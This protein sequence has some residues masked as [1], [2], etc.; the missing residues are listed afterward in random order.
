MNLTHL[1]LLQLSFQYS[2]NLKDGEWFT[3]RVVFHAGKLRFNFQHS[4]VKE[5]RWQIP[6]PKELLTFRADN[7]ELERISIRQFYLC[8]VSS[9]FAQHT[10]Q[11][12]KMQNSWSVNDNKSHYTSIAQNDNY[13]LNDLQRCLVFVLLCFI[14]YSQDM[15]L[16]SNDTNNQQQERKEREPLFGDAL[17]GEYTELYIL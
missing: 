3:G 17:M 1:L 13:I 8:S 9:S 16:K 11:L 7:I 6:P 4:H 5:L 14:F 12:I 10:L 15:L 2:W